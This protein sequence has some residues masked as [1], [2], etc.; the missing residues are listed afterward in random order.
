[1]NGTPGIRIARSAV[2][3]GAVAL[4]VAACGQITAGEAAGRAANSPDDPIE[5]LVAG[6]ER[7]A[8]ETR[9][10]AGREPGR[11]AKKARDT[12]ISAQVASALFEKLSVRATEIR[13]HT[14]ERI[15]TLIGTA[16][17]PQDRIKAEHLAMNVP[18]VRSVHNEIRVAEVPES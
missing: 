3:A 12:A 6:P 14:H 11:T 9:E 15:V 17:T 18:G 10:L 4:G 8:A 1:M 7:K 2:L 16:G 5:R 13:I